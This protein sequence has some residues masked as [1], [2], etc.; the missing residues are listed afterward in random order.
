MIAR[1]LIASLAIVGAVGVQPNFDDVRKRVPKIDSVFGTEVGER[2]AGLVVGVQGSDV[3]I[4]T[5][6]HVVENASGPATTIHISL[7]STSQPIDGATIAEHDQR[8]DIALLRLR[9]PELTSQFAD[10]GRICFRAP[11]AD[12]P[13]TTIGHPLDTL[14]QVSSVNNVILKEYNN[15]PRMFTI[16]GKGVARGSSGGPVLGADGCLLGFVSR[17][18][19]VETV[20]VTADRVANLAPAVQLSM[21]GGNSGVEAKLRRETFD[22]VSTSLNSYEFDLEAVLVMWRGRSLDGD[23]MARTI[24][25][26]NE[27]YRSMYDGRSA[28]SVQIADR[29][30]KPR[31]DD[32][33]AL[34]DFLDGG[35][36][37]L[38]YGRLQDLLT[39]LR[40]N[41]K[42][43]NSENTALTQILGEL[44]TQVT[45]SKKRVATF[46]QQLRAAL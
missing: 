22:A 38:I 28:F 15:D 36:K 17:T 39:Q 11:V 44:D 46:I 33:L 40:K 45:E 7:P 18:S 27:S 9:A 30:G 19:A 26:Y 10:A 21:L 13:V 25:H 23:Y 42:L 2:G 34:V 43:S 31:G 20:V 3:L 37:R 4:A 16:S 5:A 14:W 35:H 32:Y 24:T 12:E 41:K 1:L 29:F 8:L 6:A